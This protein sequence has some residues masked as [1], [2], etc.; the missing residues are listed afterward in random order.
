MRKLTF[1]L[2]FAVNGCAAPLVGALTINEMFSA[3]SLASSVLTGK[4]FGEYAM[5]LVTGDDCRL[6]EAVVRSERKFCEPVGSVQTTDDYKGLRTIS[7][8]I[9][10]GKSPALIGPK[11]TRR[12]FTIYD[13]RWR[14]TAFDE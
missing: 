10:E 7:S 8:Y 5:D 4:S 1:L 14:R 6:L 2:L 11:T 9:V 12:K 13:G 3:F